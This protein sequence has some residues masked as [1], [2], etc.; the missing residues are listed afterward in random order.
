MMFRPVNPQLNLNLLQSIQLP[1][2]YFTSQYLLQFAPIH[3]SV[4]STYPA[5]QWIIY[6]SKLDTQ[7]FQQRCVEGEKKANETL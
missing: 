6:V 1:S 5:K 3:P 4:G 7:Y 2:G